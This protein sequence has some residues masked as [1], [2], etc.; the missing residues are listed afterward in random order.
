MAG[1]RL[2]L[3]SGFVLEAVLA[4]SEKWRR[5]AVEMIEA[6]AVRDVDARVLWL[7]F[8]ELAQVVTRNVRGRRL[9]RDEGQAFLAQIDALALHV[10]LTLDRGMASA[11]RAAGIAIF[12][13][14]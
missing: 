5:E 3:D 9:D 13:P 2:V 6:I 12:D 7:F 11:A 4:S 14:A 10:D 8:A 1:E